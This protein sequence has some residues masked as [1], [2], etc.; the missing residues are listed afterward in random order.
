MAEHRAS[1]RAVQSAAAPTS[2][3]SLWETD[4]G[5]CAGRSGADTPF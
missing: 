1:E 3:G 2:E 4:V 5:A